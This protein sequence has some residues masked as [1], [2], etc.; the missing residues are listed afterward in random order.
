MKMKKNNLVR[1]IFISLILAFLYI[2]IL[3]IIVFSF[4]KDN[5]LTRWTG[6]SFIWYKKLFESQIIMD[7]VKVSISI[8]IL[9]TLISTIIGTLAAMS[10]ARKKRR[11]RNVVLEVNNIPIVN[12]EIVTAIGML[13]FFKMLRL[14]PGYFAMLVAHIAFCVPYVFITVY[15]KVRS[16]DPNLVEAAT[17]LGATPI[18][19]LRHAILPQ[20]K[21]AVLA[22]AA[23]AFTMS[24][25]DFVISYFTGGSSSN[26]S[27]YL[28]TLPRG[29]NPSVNALSTII[30]IIITI[31]V[32]FNYVKTNKTYKKMEERK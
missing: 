9:A 25:D 2:P 24:F 27:I 17:D 12:P 31:L 13:L 29:A 14:D 6:F 1:A 18:K 5:S 16:L 20:I 21:V 15:P 19:A 32:T 7:A 10:I 3:S 8:A 28:Y 22:A 30:I 11:F 23:I 26:I 4:N